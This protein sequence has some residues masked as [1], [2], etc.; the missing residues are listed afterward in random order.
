MS[1][2]G[3]PIII[4]LNPAKMLP[5]FT[6]NG[7]N[8]DL[9]YE[10]LS[11]GTYNWEL[12]ILSSGANDTP[13]NLKFTRVVNS[14]DIFICGS[15]AAGE[16]GYFSSG[17]SHYANGGKGGAGGATGTWTNISV[18]PNVDYPVRIGTA[19]KYINNTRTSG[20]S[21]YITIGNNTYSRNSGGG[22]DGG[23]GAKCYGNAY[24]LDY[25]EDGESGVYAFGSSNT[26]YNKGYLYG[27]SGGGG[28]TK[29]YYNM[30]RGPGVGGLIT[31]TLRAGNGG[32]YNGSGYNASVANSGSA[33]GGGGFH[34]TTYGSFDDHPGGNGATGI[35]IIRNHRS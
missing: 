8:Y 29:N 33:G 21:T 16:R 23:I 3:N 35:I 15:G 28:G 31:S 7:G 26:L 20:S 1:I 4:G 32:T 10:K 30:T 25:G 13:L 14:V 2:L 24:T 17:Y 11:D 34:E 27:A 18:S 12:A 5:S 22:K 9:K 19:G 6:Y